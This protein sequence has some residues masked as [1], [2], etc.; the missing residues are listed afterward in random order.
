LKD[1][2]YYAAFF[3]A[4]VIAFQ[5][6]VQVLTEVEQADFYGMSNLT[7]KDKPYFLR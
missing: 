1:F 2:G 5:E 6:R 3:E 7:V 4:N